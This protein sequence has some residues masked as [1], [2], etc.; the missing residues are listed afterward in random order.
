MDNIYKFILENTTA[1]KIEKQTA[2]ELLKIFYQEKNLPEDIAVTGIAVKMPKANNINELWWNLRNK[3]DCVRAFPKERAKVMNRYLDYTDKLS[4]EAEYQLGAYLEDIDQFDCNFFHLSP[5]EASLMDPSQRLFLETAFEVIEDAGYGGKKL[6]GSKTG[7]YLGYV[8]NPVYNYYRIISEVDPSVLSISFVGNLN[9]MIPSRIA[10]FLDLKGPAI[11]VN[12]ACSSSLVAIHL[13]CLGISSGECDSAIAGGVRLDLLPLKNLINVGIE[14][15]DGKTKA[16]DNN[17]DGT[18]IGEGVAAVFLKPLKKAISD[19]D[20]IYAVIKSSAVNHDGTSV[21]ITAPNITAQTD[22]LLDAWEKAKIDPETITYIEAHG[23]GTKLGDPIEI[24]GIRQ[25]FSRYT[26]KKQFCAISTVKTNMGHLYESAGIIGFIKAVLSLKNKEL[27]PMLHFNS[28]NYRI[29]FTDSPVF[30]NDQLQ[31]WETP[32]IRR[33]GVSSFGFNGTNC[34][35]VLEE[36]SVPPINETSISDPQIITISAKSEWSLKELLK[37][38]REFL[39]QSGELNIADICYTANTGRGHYN[40]RLAFIIRNQQ[41][42]ESMILRIMDDFLTINNIEGAFFGFLSLTSDNGRSAEDKTAEIDKKRLSEEASLKIQELK[43]SPN[44]QEILLKEL[45]ELYVQG[46]LIDWEDFYHEK[47]HYHLGIPV[48]PFER[49]RYWWDLPAK[50]PA[51]HGFTPMHPLVEKCVSDSDREALYVTMFSP[52]KHWVLSDHKILGNYV[53][54]GTTYLEMAR[55]ASKKFFPE[56][57]IEFRE[58]T[59]IAPVILDEEESTEVYLKLV[60]EDGYLEFVVYRKPDDSSQRITH[61][62]GKIAELKDPEPRTVRLNELELLCN[63]EEMDIQVNELTQGFVEFGPHWWNY[64]KLKNGNECSLAE[65]SLPWDLLGDLGFYY[66]HPALLDM[67]VNAKSLTLG[68]RFLPLSY[69]SLKIFGPTPAKFYSFIKQSFRGNDEQEVV[70][71]DFW[72]IEPS[73]RVFAEAEGYSLK[74]VPEFRKLIKNHFYSAVQWLPGEIQT[75]NYEINKE[76]LL[77]FMGDEE[78][79]FKRDLANHYREAGVEIIRIHSGNEF[80]ELANN[81]YQFAGTEAD[82]QKILDIIKTK[83]IKRF[84]HLAA[85]GNQDSNSI[86]MLKNNLKKGVYNLFNFVKLLLENKLGSKME[87]FVITENACEVTGTEARTIPENSSLLGLTEVIA[88]EY[89]N[90]SCRWIDIDGQTSVLELF[91]ILNAPAAETGVAIRNG[92]L[93]TRELGKVNIEELPDAKVEIKETGVYVITGG[94]GGIGIEISKYLASKNKVNLAL[95]NRSQFPKKEVWPQI[96]ANQGDSK[97]SKVIR[98]IQAMEAGS[99]TVEC[100][101]ADVSDVNEIK[102]ILAALRAK[103]GRI[104]GIIHSAGIPGKGF[105]INKDFDTFKQV[106]LP[107]INGT[108]VLNHCTENDNLDFFILFSS[109]VT[110]FCPPGQSD[111]TAANSYLDAFPAYTK[112]NR[113]K[114]L[115]IQWPAWKDTGMA[116]ELSVNFDLIIKSI[117]AIQAVYAFDEVRN[118]KINNV[119]IGE[120][121][122]EMVSSLNNLQINHKMIELHIGRGHHEEYPEIGEVVLKGKRGDTYSEIEIRVSKIWANV[123]GIRELNIYQSFNELGGDSIMAT[124]LYQKIEIE[125]PGVLDITDIFSYSSVDKMAGY[126]QSKFESSVEP[127]NQDSFKTTHWRNE[128]LEKLAKGEITPVEADR[129]IKAGGK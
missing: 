62:Q 125:F 30:I 54:P 2:V 26:N 13:A 113:N 48:Y 99:S 21:G 37:R 118:K 1:G 32:S 86:E 123:L 66:L 124:Y 128:I 72:L 70:A 4:S 19:G 53:I 122:Y 34:H 101:N 17:S 115:T 108:W 88:K 105:L 14:S 20:R 55:F 126:I 50:K 11:L 129:L 75:N 35:I 89:P 98:A 45:C 23:T 6:T 83:K 103:Y 42:L 28:P 93:F 120:I 64:R 22:V 79:G 68:K 36:A 96:L 100:Y 94:T 78:S 3:I 57:N 16:F 91:S 38:Y 87:L 67:A 119:I 114:V 44:H 116:S 27:F 127:G 10:H 43:A 80:K 15:S 71:Y 41:E 9:S 5:K 12:T 33:C 63:L 52:A 69:K 111:Y 40:Y 85:I 51:A 106:I 73:G 104:N 95:I 58:V 29:D 81:H 74:R 59:F 92:K 61:V 90:I 65:L 97:T 110:L 47:K 56:G 60:K 49:N 24:E 25:A 102:S 117:P 109:V 121:N 112:N 107:K 39:A 84:G 31:K 76:P 18:G 8:G 82:Y 46:A 7:I 77:I